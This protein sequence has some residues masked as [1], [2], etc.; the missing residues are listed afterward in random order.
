MPPLPTGGS[1]RRPPSAR[2]A[3]AA[4]SHAA[5]PGARRRRHLGH[6]L[7]ARSGTLLWPPR[8]HGSGYPR[9]PSHDRA[10]LCS[11]GWMM[12]VCSDPNSC[13]T[14]TQAEG[15]P[16][17]IL[18]RITT[19]TASPQ[20]GFLLYL[21]YQIAEGHGRASRTQPCRWQLH[22]FGLSC[23]FEMLTN[24]SNMTLLNTYSFA[25]PSLHLS[26]DPS[27]QP[28]PDPPFP[29]SKTSGSFFDST[30][31]FTLPG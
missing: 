18:T 1:R 15:F 12:D 22:N 7:L 30:S 21:P 13:I 25:Y 23:H 31:V 20:D 14:K 16:A 17:Q 8:R 4:S 28:T 29:R 11:S 9:S 19:T 2:P 5:R 24:I 6:S 26:K 27:P 10:F 3:A